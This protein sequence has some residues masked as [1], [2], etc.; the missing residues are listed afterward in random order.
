[1]SGPRLL[2]GDGKNTVAPQ[3]G[4]EKHERRLGGWKMEESQDTGKKKGPECKMDGKG[5]RK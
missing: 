1:M 5:P 4:K 3:S 2:R